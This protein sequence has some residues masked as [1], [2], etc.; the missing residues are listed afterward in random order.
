MVVIILAW[1]DSFVQ[2]EDFLDGCFA[3]VLAQPQLPRRCATVQD[4]IPICLSRNELLRVAIVD[5]SV[6]LSNSD[7]AFEVA[8]G[9]GDAF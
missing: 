6:G 3:F 7:L 2:V 4:S 5:C 8:T 9:F 1:L